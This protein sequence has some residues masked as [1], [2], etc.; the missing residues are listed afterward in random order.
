MCFLLK[1]YI[2]L[3]CALMQV[4][5]IQEV[6]PQN[7]TYVNSEKEESVENNSSGKIPALSFPL[8]ALDFVTRLATGIFSRGQ[9]SED[10]EDSDFNDA[11]ELQSHGVS[12]VSKQYSFDDS[13][14]QK[15]SAIENFGE[16]TGQG[17]A[18]DHVVFEIPVSADTAEAVC[19]LRTELDVP[20]HS[21]HDTCNFKRFDTATDP[22]DHY[23]L[24]SNTQVKFPFLISELKVNPV[25]QFWISF[26]RTY[27]LQSL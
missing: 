14:S 7:S 21:E 23:F 12:Y 9:K 4:Y 16:Q 25:V 5:V 19:N 3:F 13:S 8:A 27:L 2:F 15:S 6:G 17:K 20:K 26:A 1:S 24:G 22:S 18:E 10:Q 11:K